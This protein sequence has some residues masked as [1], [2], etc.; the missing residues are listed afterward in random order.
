MTD[1][2]ALLSS[3]TSVWYPFSFAT[4][5]SLRLSKD[6]A[7]NC[8]TRLILLSNVGTVKAET[9]NVLSS[10]TMGL[11]RTWAFLIGWGHARSAPDARWSLTVAIN[12]GG[13]GR[14]GAWLSVVRRTTVYAS[15]CNTV[16]LLEI[17]ALVKVTS[18]LM[19]MT[20]KPDALWFMITRMT[21]WGI[22][23]PTTAW[24]PTPVRKLVIYIIPRGICVSTWRCSWVLLVEGLW[25]FETLSTH[26]MIKVSRCEFV[27][28]VSAYVDHSLTLRL[29]G[30]HYQESLYSNI[31]SSGLIFHAASSAFVFVPNWP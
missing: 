4:F 30:F 23:D 2:W 16:S 22:T 10:S 19:T 9:A 8:A 12:G 18:S 5:G 17:V 6:V 21:P 7:W 29:V 15:T 11:M 20:T 25:L 24:R 31:A 14:S 26:Q 28:Q 1:T 13:V 27:L 3:R